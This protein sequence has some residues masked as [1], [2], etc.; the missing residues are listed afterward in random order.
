MDWNSISLIS[1]LAPVLLATIATLGA[2]K[3]LY[4]I[5]PKF[6]LVDTPDHRKLHS[7]SIPLT[8]GIA[9]FIGLLTSLGYAGESVFYLSC[10]TLI[11]ITGV[12]DDARDL[13]VKSRLFIQTSVALSMCLL[14]DYELS[15]LGSLIGTGNIELGWFAPAFT[16]IAVIA[17]INAFNMIDGIDDLAGSLALNTFLGMAVLFWVSGMASPLQ[18]AIIFSAGLIP[19]LLTNL[20]IGPFKNKIF[21]GD[22]GSMLIGF[23]V[24][25]LLIEGTQGT[26]QAF[27]PVTALWLIAIPLMDMAAIMFRRIKKGQSPFKPDRDHL[28][29][30]FMRAGCS[31]R[32]ALGLISIFSIVLVGIGIAGEIY[33]VP[34]PVML[35]AFLMIFFTYQ[36]AIRHVW[37]FITMFNRLK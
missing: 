13:S 26:Q 19:Y 20:T 14:G 33:T 4:P 8:G 10:A 31:P 7:G 15:S 29:H 11:V 6:G 5:A 1:Y 24:I 30:I 9:L 27:R 25:W 37:R 23:T 21:M 34:E 35:V 32:Q 17:A 22:A 36:Y 3:T 16:T 12:L 18:L 28:H 2:I